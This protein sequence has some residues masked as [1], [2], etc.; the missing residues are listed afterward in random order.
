MSRSEGGLGAPSLAETLT[1]G[2][3]AWL[4]LA[5][6]CIGAG[7]FL[8]HSRHASKPAKK[9]PKQA[10]ASKSVEAAN[11]VPAGPALQAEV[12]DSGVQPPDGF[13]VSVVGQRREWIGIPASMSL[14]PGA[15]YDTVE[16]VA[17]VC[18][19]LITMAAQQEAGKKM[20]PAT[21]RTS[22]GTLIPGKAGSVFVRVTCG[23]NT[24]EEYV[25]VPLTPNGR[26]RLWGMAVKLVDQAQLAQLEPQI[27]QD[28]KL[29]P[30]TD[31][32]T[33]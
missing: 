29:P 32:T 16:Q 18:E 2:W 4:C 22:A 14:A 11:S 7:T 28:E 20:S 12:H 15:N 31:A 17:R 5:L 19:S 9:S 1:S 10:V 21:L 6:F 8:G 13:K 26:N 23:A 30:A 25:E 27:R 3:V 33:P 24:V